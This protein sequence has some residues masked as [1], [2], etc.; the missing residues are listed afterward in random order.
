MFGSC[1]GGSEPGVEISSLVM[2]W[3][4]NSSDVYDLNPSFLLVFELLSGKTKTVLLFTLSVSRYRQMGCYLGTERH[5]DMKSARE[6][7]S[8]LFSQHSSQA[9]TNLSW[10]FLGD[11][12]GSSCKSCQFQPWRTKTVR[13]TT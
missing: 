6:F 1:S 11:C 9:K 3:L 5:N 12:I 7:R 4:I 8:G 13:L 2:F 10:P